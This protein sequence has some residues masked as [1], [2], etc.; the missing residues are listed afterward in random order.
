MLAMPFDVGEAR[1]ELARSL[2]VQAPESARDEARTAL[3]AFDAL[4]ATRAVDAA[5]GLLRSLGGAGGRS[6]A[7]PG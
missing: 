5:A 2:A 4:G 7:R 3:A 6:R 1:L